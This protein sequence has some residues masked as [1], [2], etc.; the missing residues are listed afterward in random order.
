M[1]I[2]NK[3]VSYDDYMNKLLQNPAEAKEYARAIFEE[4]EKDN[5]Q[6]A[7]LLGLHRLAIAQGG[8]SEFA[9]KTSLNRQN[10]YKIFSGKS[11]PRIDTLSALLRG[12]GLHLTVEANTPKR[13]SKRS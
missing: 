3:T 2:M 9:E 4:Y 6:Q 11:V 10:L 7:L 5:D 13:S 12:L 1:K 8:M